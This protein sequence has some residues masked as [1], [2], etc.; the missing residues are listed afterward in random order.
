MGLLAWLFGTNAPQRTDASA[1]SPTATVVRNQPM[2]ME[3]YPRVVTE[4]RS[5]PTNGVGELRYQDTLIAIFG[6]YARVKQK[7]LSN[8]LLE[9]EP[10]NPHDSNAVMIKIKGQKVAYLARADAVRVGSS[11]R[12][13]GHA[14]VLCEALVSG[15]WRTNQHDTG[16]YG[17]FLR[18]PKRGEIVF[19]A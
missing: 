13:A 7:Y 9:L 10:S 12:S 6:P 2:V 3:K 18:I 4:L 17:V 11:M 14:A 16:P 1:Q 5:F 8:A 15:G 19:A